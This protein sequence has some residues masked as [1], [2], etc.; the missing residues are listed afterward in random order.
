MHLSFLSLFG[1]QFGWKKQNTFFLSIIG[2]DYTV[3]FVFLPGK[4]CATRNT[5]SWREIGRKPDPHGYFPYRSS[6]YMTTPPRLSKLAYILT[7]FVGCIPKVKSPN[8]VLPS[9]LPSPA[10][11]DLLLWIWHSSLLTNSRSFHELF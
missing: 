1:V 2:I 4:A 6:V 5:P 10:W 9:P 11:Q 3:N 7:L 8:L